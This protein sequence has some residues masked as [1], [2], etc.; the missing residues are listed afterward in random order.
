MCIKILKSLDF[1]TI[2]MIICL[3]FIFSL[4]ILNKL[5]ILT[6]WLLYIFLGFFFAIMVASLIISIKKSKEQKKEPKKEAK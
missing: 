3:A 5:G 6:G 2:V 4:T 1:Y